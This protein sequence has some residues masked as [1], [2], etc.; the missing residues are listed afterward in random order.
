MVP[1]RACV[2][3]VARHTEAWLSR[4][5]TENRHHM[6]RGS[7]G[8]EAK[9]LRMGEPFGVCSKFFFPLLGTGGPRLMCDVITMSRPGSSSQGV[10]HRTEDT[11]TCSS[12]NL[13]KAPQGEAP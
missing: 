12:K 4:P 3:P 9:D 13:A 1:H 5:G 11:P 7:V 2:M 10:L 8:T 6:H